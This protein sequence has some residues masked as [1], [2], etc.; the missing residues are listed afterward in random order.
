MDKRAC[1][2]YVWLHFQNARSNTAHAYMQVYASYKNMRDITEGAKVTGQLLQSVRDLGRAEA[3]SLQMT[4]TTSHQSSSNSSSSTLSASSGIP[5]QP[6]DMRQVI[7]WQLAWRGLM[8]DLVTKATQAIKAETGAAE[9]KDVHINLQVC[10]PGNSVTYLPFRT[11]T[12]R[13]MHAGLS[14]VKH[15][16]V[17]DTS[18]PAQLGK[19]VLLMCSCKLSCMMHSCCI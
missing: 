1:K 9:V 8:H 11:F 3:K 5:L 12:F 2:L 16:C 15:G 6:P 10:E 18:V 19:H 7:A 4:S 13:G 14:Y 17:L